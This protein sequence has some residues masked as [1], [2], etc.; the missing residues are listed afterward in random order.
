M[1]K[2]IKILTVISVAMTAVS[3]ILYNLTGAGFIL[4]LA[5]TFGT[6]SYH[7]IMRLIVGTVV[8]ALSHNQMDYNRRWFR[9]H[10]FEKKLYRALKIKN[11]KKSIP[12][13]NPDNFSLEI[14][15]LHEIAQATCVAEIVHEII[16]VLSFVPLFFT[17]LFGAWYVFLI[18]SIAAACYD[19]LFVIVQRY[20]RPR[21]ISLM[22]MSGKL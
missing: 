9:Q 21:I 1:A 17:L 7:F 14:H 6:T 18:T 16:I 15:S 19:L 3:I 22:K 10:K 20:N 8:A 5:I 13:Y 4:S 11:L 2:T 12:T